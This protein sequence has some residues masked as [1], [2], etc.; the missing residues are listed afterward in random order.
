MRRSLLAALLT[1]AALPAA[2]SAAPG[3][4]LTVPADVAS[5]ALSCP[6]T[7]TAPRGPVLLVHG[8]GSDADA[9]TPGMLPALTRDGFD[10]CRV[11]LPE[12]AWA[13]IQL[14]AEYVVAAVRRI[15]AEA[16]RPV[17]IVG[18]S[19]GGMLPRW[20]LKWWPDV[21]TAISMLIGIEPSNHGSSAVDALCAGPCRAAA[22]QQGP[23]SSFLA[24]LNAGAETVAEVPHTTISSTSDAAVSPTSSRLAGGATV[25]NVL[26]QAVCPGRE[27]AHGPAIDDAATYALTLDALTHGGLAAPERIDR[28]VCAQQWIAG[29]DAE[30]IERNQSEHDRFFV[31]S[32]PM[33]ALLPAEPAV[34][35]YALE[36]PPVPT[37]RLIV[38]P[39]R[40][41][42]GRRTRLRLQ[43]TGVSGAETFPLSGA[44]IRLAGRTLVTGADGRAVTRITIRK[45]GLRRATLAAGGL[46]PARTRVRVAR[47][48]A[49][50]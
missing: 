42:A 3:P 29:S 4:P 10:V 15:S 31:S 28:A 9:W 40:V 12:A 6:A 5:Q 43:A 39:K 34:K 27:V 18:H 26:T 44:R 47:A 37:A 13:D 21:R 41:T 8:T 23:G 32:Y 16:R 48:R 22:W 11:A 7:F 14:S 36:A 17:A 33:G 46:A 49:R 30:E 19:Q 24:R 1:L 38:T 20:A 2:A 35:A 25:A 45:A 50:G